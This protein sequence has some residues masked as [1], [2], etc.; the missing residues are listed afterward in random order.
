MPALLSFL[1]LQHLSLLELCRHG[2]CRHEFLTIQFPVQDQLMSYGSYL[3][4][5]STV[6]AFYNYPTAGRALH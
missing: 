6:K 2:L 5:I 4:K 1:S 3:Q